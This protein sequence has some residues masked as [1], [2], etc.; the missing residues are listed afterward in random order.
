MNP[1]E[2]IAALRAELENLRTE[3]NMMRLAG[4]LSKEHS[5]RESA[6]EP[7]VWSR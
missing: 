4:V 1:S 6:M 2:E 5:I 7:S 3:N